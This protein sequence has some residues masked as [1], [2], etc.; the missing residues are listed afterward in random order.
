MSGSIHAQLERTVRTVLPL[1]VLSVLLTVGSL[2]AQQSLAIRY[3]QRVRITAP[4]C[5][6]QGLVTT[7][8]GVSGDTLVLQTTSCPL[9]S[10]TRAE[11]SRE[12]ESEWLKG[13]L[14]G[15]F[16]GIAI[17]VPASGFVSCGEDLY[18]ACPAAG[19]AL[20]RSSPAEKVVTR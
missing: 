11:V 8:Y 6:I 9:G 14:V 13:A 2:H 12:R 3:F 20:G 16:S 5:G 4:A 10:V 17:G 15:L 19:A 1:A 7:Y 18:G